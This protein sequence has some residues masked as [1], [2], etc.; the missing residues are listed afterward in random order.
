VTYKSEQL[1][2]ELTE[3]IRDNKGA[4]CEIAPDM[5][6]LDKDDKMGREKMRV[7]KEVCG[8]CPMRL[9][10]L[11]YALEANEQDGIWGGLTRNE[12]N[13]LNR[14]RILTSARLY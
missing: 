13:A 8:S 7:A 2:R 4:P 9:L 3:R 6:F 11:E 14:K 10:C 5:F 12:R 1:Y